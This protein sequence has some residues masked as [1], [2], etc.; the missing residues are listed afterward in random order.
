VTGAEKPT[1]G[2]LSDQAIYERV[3]SDE[4]IVKS[5]FDPDSLQPAS[6]DLQIARDGLITPGG[7]KIPPGA[8]GDR[9]AKVVLYPG[10]AALFSTVAMLRM[11][12]DVA[13][14]VTIK[15]RLATE[16]LMLLSGLLVD[17]GYGS[18][19]TVD[20]EPGCRLYLHVANIGKDPVTIRPGE[21]RIARLQF[22]RVYGG[23]HQSRPKIEASEWNSQEQPS[24][25][26]LTELRELK[27]KVESTNSQVQNVVM[28]GFVVLGVTLFGVVVATVLAIVSK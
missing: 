17:P 12:E 20:S 15:N 14:N 25:G 26:F 5:T 21:D 28:L 18:D 1:S 23:R 19:E 16:G 2:V 13:G 8:D 4:L 22:L 11:P 7:E 9:P 24:L 6:Y 3:Q 27:E 10:Q